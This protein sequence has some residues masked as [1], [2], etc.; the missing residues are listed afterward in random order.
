MIKQILF[1]ILITLSLAVLA[2]EKVL[3]KKN[4]DVFEISVLSSDHS[5]KELRHIPDSSK[6]LL[7]ASLEGETVYKTGF[8][9]HPEVYGMTNSPFTAETVIPGSLKYDNL[10]VVENIGSDDMTTLP[11]LYNQIPTSYVRRLRL[12]SESYDVHKIIDN[13]DDSNRIVFVVLGDG[14]VETEI[15]K[16]KTDAEKLINYIFGK[17]PWKSYDKVVNVYRIDVISNESGA[18]HP[19]LNPPVSVDTALD[20]RYNSRLLTVNT[21]KAHGIAN[22]VT[23]YDQILVIVNDKRRKHCSNFNSI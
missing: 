16:Y 14:Y 6:Y 23:G 12:A 5:F 3:I 13:G 1:F 10:E 2:G 8:H 22:S 15:E 7:V 20:A 19:G 4:G 9:L 11:S 18:D 21:S 17:E